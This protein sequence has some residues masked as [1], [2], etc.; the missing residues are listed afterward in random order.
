MLTLCPGLR[1]RLLEYVSSANANSITDCRHWLLRV[2]VDGIWDFCHLA[3]IA[4]S[5]SIVGGVS[6]A[7]SKTAAAPIERVKLL[8]QNQVCYDLS[9]CGFNEPHLMRSL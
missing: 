6:A 8:I 7:V 4:N 1:G 3:Q 9:P 5:S 2:D